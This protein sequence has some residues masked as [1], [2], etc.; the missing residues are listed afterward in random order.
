MV[1]A[2]S[3]ILGNPLLHPQRRTPTPHTFGPLSFLSSSR[4]T[5]F[6]SW[7]PTRAPTGS[8]PL[9]TRSTSHTRQQERAYKHFLRYI[10]R[11]RR[12]I[13]RLSA[14]M[15]ADHHRHARLEEKQIGCQ[16]SQHESE[17]VSVHLSDP[18]VYTLSALRM[19]PVQVLRS[20]SSI[21]AVSLYSHRV[22][23]WCINP[24]SYTHLTLPTKA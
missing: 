18:A 13:S 21:E 4:S 24:V 7:T 6:L 17:E 20:S 1:H 22:C 12:Q 9:S 8:R 16:P 11:S 10:S 2:G 5:F 15:S 19:D 23:S 3:V 14:P